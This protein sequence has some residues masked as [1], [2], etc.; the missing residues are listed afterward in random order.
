MI[1]RGAQKGAGSVSE[2]QKGTFGAIRLVSLRLKGT[3]NIPFYQA[4]S[5][6]SGLALDAI[7]KPTL[8]LRFLL[9]LCLVGMM[10]GMVG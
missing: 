6:Q 1:S 4:E 3:V 7:W 10:A 8:S 2:N 5:K 9:K